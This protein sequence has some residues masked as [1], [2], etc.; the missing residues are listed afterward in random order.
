MAQWVLWAGRDTC[1]ILGAPFLLDFRGLTGK[2][3]LSIRPAGGTSSEPSGRLLND[4]MTVT[5]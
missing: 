5:A 1:L 2:A 3:E 4:R